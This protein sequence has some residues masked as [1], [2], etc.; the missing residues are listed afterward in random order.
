MSEELK[1]EAEE[2]GD[3]HSKNCCVNTAYGCDGIDE[4][5]ECC[6][7]MK[8]ISKLIAKATLAERKRWENAR[9]L[10]NG[11]ADGIAFDKESG[12]IWQ[13][14]IDEAKKII[15]TLNQQDE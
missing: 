15:K 6:D 8:F 10:I 5:C 2:A 12:L 3:M 13:H 1:K 4:N 9:Q 11:L 7:N 14:W